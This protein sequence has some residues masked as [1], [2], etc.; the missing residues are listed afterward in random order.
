[1]GHAFGILMAHV[2]TLR[3]FGAPAPLTLGVRPLQKH[4][5]ETTSACLR[6]KFI[7]PKPVVSRKGQVGLRPHPLAVFRLASLQAIRLSRP[8]GLSVSRGQRTTGLLAP[9]CLEAP[10]H[11]LNSP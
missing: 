1:M 6:F 8:N 3:T 9:S 11:K 10:H 4:T 5:L 7:E 2:G